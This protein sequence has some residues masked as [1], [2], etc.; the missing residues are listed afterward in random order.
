MAPADSPAP[1]GGDAIPVIASA[2][3]NSTSAATPSASS[4]LSLTPGIVSA[5]QAFFVVLLPPH[6]VVV[7]ELEGLL[8]TSHPLREVGVEGGVV[9]GVEV[10][11]IFLAGQTG[12]TVRRDDQV[13]IGATR[14]DVAHRFAPSTDRSS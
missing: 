8:A 10:F 13:A 9:L 3:G 2:S 5:F 1:K 7:V 12:M 6:D 14:R 11:A 4:S